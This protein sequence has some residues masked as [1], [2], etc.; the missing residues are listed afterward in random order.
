MTMDHK[1]REIPDE[2]DLDERERALVRWLLEH[3]TRNAT[4][5]A[6]PKPA[7]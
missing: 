4:P 3:G 6:T 2:R 5:Y 1:S 7:R